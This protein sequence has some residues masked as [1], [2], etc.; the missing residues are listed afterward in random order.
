M[1]FA[2]SMRQIY[3]SALFKKIGLKPF[4]WSLLLGMAYTI[5]A[6]RGDGLIIGGDSII[7][8]HSVEYLMKLSYYSNPWAGFGSNLPPIFSFPPLPDILIFS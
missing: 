6:Y 5:L 7:P 3:K 8:L 1:L 4:A 2:L